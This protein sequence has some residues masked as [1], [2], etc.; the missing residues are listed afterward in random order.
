MTLVAPIEIQEN[1]IDI[2]G[3]EL[4]VGTLHTRYA[5]QLVICIQNL[6]QDPSERIVGVNQQDLLHAPL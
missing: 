6:L 2:A 1:H 5:P 3:I 4:N